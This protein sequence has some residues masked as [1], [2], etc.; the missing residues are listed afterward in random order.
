MTLNTAISDYKI[1]VLNNLVIVIFAISAFCAFAF[2]FEA[3]LASFDHSFNESENFKASQ[4]KLERFVSYGSNVDTMDMMIDS[5]QNSKNPKACN[6]AKSSKAK[7]NMYFGDLDF[8]GLDSKEAKNIKDADKN[9]TKSTKQT[10]SKTPL[11][12]A[13]STKTTTKPNN[14][15]NRTITIK[16]TKATESKNLHSQYSWIKSIGLVMVSF[17]DGSFKSGFGV[18]LPDKMFLTSAELAHNASAYPKRILLKMRDESSENLICVAQLYLNLVDKT[19]GLAL[20]KITDYTDDH[21]NIRNQSYYHKYMFENNAIKLTNMRAPSS[22]NFYTIESSFDD[23]NV[24]VLRINDRKTLPIEDKKV[25]FGRPFFNK[26]GDFLGLT[27]MTKNEIK[28]II[29]SQKEIKNFICSM[30]S[31]GLKAPNSIRSFCSI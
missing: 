25:I 4:E 18:L 26:N 7:S 10:T 15:Q 28:P 9:A 31:S 8:V 19:Q 24:N 16:N 30:R 27:T 13:N 29:I 2:G 20:F 14:T 17:D 22:S 21:C 11:T 1:N 6:K 12:K 23:L 3:K 5:C